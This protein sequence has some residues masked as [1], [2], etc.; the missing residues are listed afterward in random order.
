M[1]DVNE[2]T[3]LCNYAMSVQHL[4]ITFSYVR[5][6]GR[7]ANVMPCRAPSFTT[8]V[9]TPLFT[10]CPGRDNNVQDSVL[11]VGNI[12]CRVKYSI[13]DMHMSTAQM[14]KPRAGN[15]SL[16]ASE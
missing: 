4:N 11:S 13:S 16:F 8:T 7:V 10:H 2:M 12:I 15:R 6:R 1:G 3:L 14:V 5:G 9:P